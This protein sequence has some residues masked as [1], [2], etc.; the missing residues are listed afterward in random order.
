MANHYKQE[1]NSKGSM[2]RP[3]GLANNIP[4]RRWIPGRCPSPRHPQNDPATSVP[5]RHTPS[6]KK[7]RWGIQTEKLKAAAEIKDNQKSRKNEKSQ[8]NINIVLQT[9]TYFHL[10]TLKGVSNIVVTEALL[11]PISVSDLQKQENIWIRIRS[12]WS[13]DWCIWRKSKDWMSFS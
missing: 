1:E 6:R 11:P 10:E 5:L 8:F 3:R 2:W 7:S 9:V 4:L 13:T 12:T